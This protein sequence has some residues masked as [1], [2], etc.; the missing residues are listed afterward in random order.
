MPDLPALPLGAPDRR[1]RETG[2]ASRPRVEGPGP[3][4]QQRRLGPALD[5]LTTAFD[6]GRV[7]VAEDPEAREPEQVLVMEIA[8]QIDEFVRAVQRVEGLEFLAEEIEDKVDPDEFAAV[9]RDGRRHRYARQLFLVM[10]DRTAWQQLLNLWERFQRG[11][12]FPRGL[13]PFRH[14]FALLRELRPWDDRDRLERTGALETWQRELAELDQELVEFEIELWL[15]ADTERRIAAVADLRADLEKADGEFVAELVHEEIDYHGVLGR[16]P[17]NRLLDAVEHH[18]VRWLRTGGVRFFHA[19]GQMAAPTGIDEAEIERLEEAAGE[20]VDGDVH[21]AVLD[22]LPLTGHVLLRDRLVVDDPDGWEQTIPAARRVHGTGMASVVIHGDI[23]GDAT[24]LSEPV[25][26][27]PILAADAP[28]WIPEP[29]EELPRDRIAV[30][31]VHSAVAR[32]FEGEEPAAPAVK[33]IVLALGDAALQFDRFVSPLARLLDWLSFRHQ[34]LFLVSAGNHLAPL[35][36]PTD[37][38]TEDPQEI[39]HELLC[40]IGRKAAYRRLLSPAESINA[41]TIGAAHA[42]NATYRE[43]AGRIEPVVTPDLP[44]VI[45]A[46]GGGMRRAVKPDILL[47]GGRQL[48]RLEPAEDGELRLVSFPVSRR[49]P[50]VRMAAPG[51]TAG[52]L[53]ATIHDTGTSVATAI[54]GHHAGHL[55]AT[56][57]DLRELHGDAIA[58]EELDAVLVKAVLLHSARWGAAHAFV[59]EVQ[60]ELGQSR[61]RDAVARRVGYGLA[62]PDRAIVCDN[63]IATT[64]AAGRIGQDRAHSYRFPLP[65]SLASRTDRRRISLTLAWLTPIN[66]RHRNYRRAALKLDPLAPGHFLGDRT[67]AGMYDARR[68]TAQHEV[69]LGERAV[70]YAPGAALELVVSCRADAGALEI[71]VPYAVIATVEVPEEIELPIYEEVRQALRVPVAVRAG[72]G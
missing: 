67:D 60:Q 20:G 15:R 23:N 27:R 25:Y 37:V 40:A 45:S 51:L 42:D 11:E 34:V 30:D 4:T 70:P 38:G 54:A 69:L 63:H 18:E 1:A 59:D 44:S 35:E 14:L 3:E 61:S 26:V 46:L 19:V 49:A 7:A 65:P 33:V 32:L 24:P 41:L 50:G 12:A 29:R 72:R 48:A 62:A 71:E 39:Q 16:V 36:V 56:L 5:R 68:G 52:V 28:S 17:A 58:G 2:S 22:G 8:G 66:P 13:T 10:S 64:L 43:E 57:S 53:D 6:A 47:P 9:D 21:I 55:L 31:L